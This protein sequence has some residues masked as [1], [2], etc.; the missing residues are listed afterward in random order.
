MILHDETVAM[1]ELQAFADE[2]P[3]RAAAPQRRAARHRAWAQRLRRHIQQALRPETI[4]PDPPS[5]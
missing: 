5:H 1:L 2:A 4:K 3:A